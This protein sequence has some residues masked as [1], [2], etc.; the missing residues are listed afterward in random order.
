M[1]NASWYYSITKRAAE[2]AAK[3]VADRD[4]HTM[5]ALRYALENVRRVV[6]QFW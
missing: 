1:I 2:D 5:D 3:E 4:N 6:H